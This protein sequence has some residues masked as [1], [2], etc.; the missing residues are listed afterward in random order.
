MQGKSLMAATSAEIVVVKAVVAGTQQ[1]TDMDATVY[2]H[3]Q[4]MSA[5]VVHKHSGFS[6]CGGCVH[7]AEPSTTALAAAGLLRWLTCCCVPAV[8]ASPIALQSWLND[9]VNTFSGVNGSFSAGYALLTAALL[10]AGL[11]YI[12]APGLTLQGV[13][14]DLQSRR[15]LTSSHISAALCTWMEMKLSTHKVLAQL[16]G[17]QLTCAAMLP[18]VGTSDRC[19]APLLPTAVARMRSCCGS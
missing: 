16:K 8:V 17:G 18:A 13:S 2:G 14:G 6:S 19:L 1:D 9:A 10:G 5:G 7:Q 4:Q 12:V 11:G 15:V 3:R